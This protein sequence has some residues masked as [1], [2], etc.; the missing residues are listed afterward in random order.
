MANRLQLSI[1]HPNI[2]RQDDHGYQFLYTQ[3]VLKKQ[4]KVTLKGHNFILKLNPDRT[5]EVSSEG[6]RAGKAGVPAARPQERMAPRT[7]A[8]LLEAPEDYLRLHAI[9]QQSV[10]RE[11]GRYVQDLGRPPTEEDVRFLASKLGIVPSDIRTAIAAAR[12]RGAEVPARASVLE[13]DY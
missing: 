2:V 4:P 3:V 9:Y 8:R 1:D 10:D 13:H 11:I 12:T 5:I 7:F 6:L